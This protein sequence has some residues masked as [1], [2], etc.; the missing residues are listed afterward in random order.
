MRTLSTSAMPCSEGLLVVRRVFRDNPKANQIPFGATRHFKT[1]GRTRGR[2][3]RLT[4]SVRFGRGSGDNRG[5]I[6]LTIRCRD[7]LDDGM[8]YTEQQAGE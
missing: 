1:S 4:C 7:F 5:G 6:Q 2:M 8:N 3:H